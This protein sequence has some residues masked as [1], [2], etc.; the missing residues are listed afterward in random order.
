MARLRVEDTFVGDALFRVLNSALVADVRKT[1][2]EMPHHARS[3]VWSHSQHAH[4][5][6]RPFQTGLSEGKQIGTWLDATYVNIRP[7][8]HDV[9]LQAR[10]AAGALKLIAGFTEQCDLVAALFT[11]NWQVQNQ[12]FGRATDFEGVLIGLR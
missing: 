7:E 5:I 1:P 6:S 2:L 3:Q 8:R 9:I 10:R 12:V 4:V 11:S